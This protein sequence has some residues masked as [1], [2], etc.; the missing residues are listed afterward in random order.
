M[1][2]QI[3]PEPFFSILKLDCLGTAASAL[4]VCRVLLNCSFLLVALSASAFTQTPLLDLVHQTFVC[5]ASLANLG[6]VLQKACALTRRR[7]RTP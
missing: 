2:K 5:F 3:E 1:G 4:P 7:L 6:R